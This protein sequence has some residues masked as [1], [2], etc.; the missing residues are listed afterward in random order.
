L[1]EEY[2]RVWWGYFS[3]FNLLDYPSIILPI[4][5]V[6]IDAERCELFSSR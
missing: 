1:H 6:K 4:K 5:D 2:F 3:L